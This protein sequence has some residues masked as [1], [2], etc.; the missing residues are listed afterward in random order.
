MEKKDILWV[1][2]VNGIYMN[3][4]NDFCTQ[5]PPNDSNWYW[6][7]LHKIKLGMGR[8]YNGGVYCLTS[9]KEYSVA[10][11]YLDLMGKATEMEAAELI[12]S[13][14]VLPKHRFLLWLA[15][16]D[17]LLTKERMQRIG[18]GC[19]NTRC[20]MCEEDKLEN[21]THL[22]YE[23][24]WAEEAW[25][26][27]QQWID[28]KLQHR[29]IKEALVRIKHK[30]QSRFKKGVMAT[31]YGAMIYQIWIARNHRI[32]RGQ[33]VHSSFSTANSDSN[34]GENRRVQRIKKWTEECFSYAEVV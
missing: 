21:S 8:Q 30:H 2:W 25:E 23:C 7:K 13:R 15:A 18:I 34:Q 33:S 3:N 11:G 29:E 26:I 28:V 27:L 5:T 10:R 14:I 17:R 4:S 6:R 24:N 31:I 19:D 20:G 22:F 9:N 16:Q 1:K 32:F 12:W